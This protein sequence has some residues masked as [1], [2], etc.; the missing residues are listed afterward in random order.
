MHKE[1]WERR[2][3][4]GRHVVLDLNDDE[5]TYAAHGADGS[6]LGGGT[7]QDRGIERYQAWQIMDRVIDAD[8]PLGWHQVGM[9]C[10]VCGELAHRE[11]A[12]DQDAVEVDCPQCLVYTMS[13]PIFQSI[14]KWTDGQRKALAAFL[15]R[16]KPNDDRFVTGESA[17]TMIAEGKR[18]LKEG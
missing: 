16:W 18:R 11:R 5:W 14:A 6:D 17:E 9:A 1:R 15:Q 2:Y 7:L 4:D 10:P 12:A 8:A 13:G 3:K